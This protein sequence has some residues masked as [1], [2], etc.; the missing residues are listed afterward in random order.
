MFPGSRV[1]A[2]KSFESL[3]RKLES[4]FK[5]HILYNSFMSEY[6]S[7]GHM[8]IGNSL[9][10]YFISHNAVFK[11]DDGDVKIRVVFDA[12]ARCSSGLLLNN[13]LYPR[14]KLQ[15]DIIDV[16]TRFRVFRHAFTTD[17]CKMYRQILVQTEFRPFQYIL[18]RP[19]PH[20]KLVEYELNTV[21]YG[22]N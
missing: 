12:S 19:S 7:L 21:T 6:L 14:P 18:W 17:I 20:D 15:Q 9:G 2:V 22:I 11:A 1:V 8:S 5:L 10:Q 3:E 16:M 4:D 13:S